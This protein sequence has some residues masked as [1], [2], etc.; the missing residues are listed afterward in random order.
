MPSTEIQEFKTRR[1]AY[2]KKHMVELVELELKHAKV[3]HSIGSLSPPPC[4]HLVI[5]MYT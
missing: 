1:I 4:P 3:I 2:F 5:Y